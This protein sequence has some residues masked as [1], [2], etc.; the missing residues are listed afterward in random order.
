M[1]FSCLFLFI[2]HC[3]FFVFN[4]A[5]RILIFFRFRYVEQFLAELTLF[6]K[7]YEHFIATVTRF[8]IEWHLSQ[9]VYHVR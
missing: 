3:I 7:N 8:M 6:Q 9:Y 5:M 1:G 4:F 2:F